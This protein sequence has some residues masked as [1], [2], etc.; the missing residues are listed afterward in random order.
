MRPKH[1][2]LISS[3]ASLAFALPYLFVL[4]VWAPPYGVGTAVAFLAPVVIVT[5]AKRTTTLV[6]LAAL[7]AF[8]VQSLIFKVWDTLPRLD[9]LEWY[10]AGAILAVLAGMAASVV[11][12]VKSEEA[13]E[14]EAVARAAS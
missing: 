4:I 6:A 14:V 11:A 5:I 3:I 12:I 7:G 13:A 2:I 9:T 10:E 8:I 1:A